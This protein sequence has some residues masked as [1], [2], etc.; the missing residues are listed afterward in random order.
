M[1]VEFAIHTSDL[2]LATSQLKANR[3]EYRDSDTVDI[4]VSECV[5]TFRAVGTETEV[6]VNGKQT[7]SVRLSLKS[8]RDLLKVALSFKKK[9]V[10]FLFEPGEAKVETFSRS[11]PDIELGTIPDQQLLIPVDVSVLD[12]LALAEI[13][14]PSR[15]SRG[16]EGAGG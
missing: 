6:P 2:R 12:T 15:R 1:T 10:R 9:E 7:G 8:L 5:A 4:L 14:G 13:L 3:G 16:H 11:H